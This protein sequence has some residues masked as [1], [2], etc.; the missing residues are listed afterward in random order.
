MKLKYIITTLTLIIVLF[1]CNKDD[2]GAT[3]NFDAAAQ[4]IIDD[5][6]LVDYFQTHYYIPAEQDEPFGSID[7]ILNNETPLSSQIQSKSVTFND[8][9]YK[10]YHLL[11]EEGVNESPNRLDSVLVRYRG[12][13]LDSTK[14]DERD[15]FY[16]WFQQSTPGLREGW[17]HGFE[18]FK[19]G[20][21][22][23]L[24]GEPITFEDTGKGVIFFPSGLGYTNFGT[25]G[26]PPNEPLIFH[27]ELAQ[28]INPDSD[29]DGILDE[30]E[31]LDGDGEVFDE[32]T[33]EDTFPNYA[34]SD[35]D[36]DGILTKDEDANEDGD[37]TNDDTDG[38]GVP[39]YLDSDS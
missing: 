34:D 31:D 3:D 25:T 21:H 28:V 20:N 27:V 16:L 32:D 39:D 12:F 23:I 15:K 18:N 35:D 11:V 1:S 6:R 33:D 10:V 24:Q 36:N 14:F 29:N 17:R 38:D 30:N 8:I 2:D 5:E 22:I 19:S 7:T 37:P 26:I 4:A 13:L 9:N